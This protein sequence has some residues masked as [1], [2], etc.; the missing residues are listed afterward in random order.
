MVDHVGTETYNNTVNF[1]RKHNMKT[2]QL[3]ILPVTSLIGQMIR[4]FLVMEGIGS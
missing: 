2:Y 4:R 3:S 1:R